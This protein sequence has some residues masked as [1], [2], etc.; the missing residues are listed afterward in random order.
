MRAVA[1]S[2]LELFA[3]ALTLFAAAL[4][5]V[6]LCLLYTAEEIYDRADDISE[7]RWW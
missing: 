7:F 4:I 1:K 5:L 2:L 3:T 6:P